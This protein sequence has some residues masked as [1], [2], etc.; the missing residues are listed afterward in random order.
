M[1]LPEGEPW[2]R[3][4]CGLKLLQ[5]MAIGIPGVASPIGVN[6]E[7]VEN[8]C[9]GFLATSGD[10]WQTALRRLLEDVELRRKL[11]KAARQ[12][13]EARYSIDVHFPR[14][15]AALEDAIARSRR[16]MPLR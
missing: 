2:M 16:W 4:K 13:V 5:Y 15:V 12:T 3:Y 10:E 6:T 1:P 8:G 11:G 9:N 14:F 7:I